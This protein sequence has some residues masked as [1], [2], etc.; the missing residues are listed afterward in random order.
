MDMIITDFDIINAND[1]ITNHVSFHLKR[2]NVYCLM[3]F[4]RKYRI[5]KCMLLYI[6]QNFLKK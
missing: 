4:G 1:E 2:K 6:E 3:I 5:Y